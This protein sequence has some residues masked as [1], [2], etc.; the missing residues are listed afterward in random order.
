MISIVD[1]GVGNVQAIQNVYKRLNI[2][3]ARVRT[4]GE[5]RDAT[6]LILPGVG[7]FDRA[8]DLLDQSGM[9]ETLDELVLQRQVPVLGICVGMQMLMQR[10]EEGE[11]PGL[12]WIPGSVRSFKTV[13]SPSIMVPHLGWDDVRPIVQQ[14]LFTGLVDDVRFYFLHSYFVVCDRPHDVAATCQYEFDFACAVKAGNI[15]GVQFHPEK[16]HHYGTQLLRNFAD[17]TAC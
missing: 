1:Y 13:G 4:S 3:T 5:L 16:S 9:R 7:A 8:M 11:R 17:A 6:Q 14:P 15:H 10:S 2:E 12:G